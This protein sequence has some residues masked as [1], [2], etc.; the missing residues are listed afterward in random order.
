MHKLRNCQKVKYKQSYQIWQK[1]LFLQACTKDL[2]S[3]RIRATVTGFSSEEGS[4]KSH[5]CWK[6]LF[7]EPRIAGTNCLF[8]PRPLISDWGN[9]IKRCLH[10]SEKYRKKLP[11]QWMEMGM[12]GD[13][14]MIATNIPAIWLLANSGA[15]HKLRNTEAGRGLG[16]RALLGQLSYISHKHA[17]CHS[18]VAQL[19]VQEDTAL[20]VASIIY[21]S[22]AFQF[23]DSAFLFFSTV[24]G[25]WSI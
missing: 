19:M 18:T 16:L 8:A 3:I 21:T 11:K 7:T 15:I 10:W 9:T 13:C 6:E 5:R 14:T 23:W 12:N 2:N 1:D 22:T 24:Y 4:F 17:S 20:S 25:D